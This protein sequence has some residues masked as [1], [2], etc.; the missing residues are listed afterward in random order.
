M[1]CQI[2]RL[3][4]KTWRRAVSRNTAA[5]MM[6]AKYVE[7]YFYPWVMSLGIPAL[8]KISNGKTVL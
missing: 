6:T 1:I 4:L 8:R 3:N 7:E 5:R 2:L